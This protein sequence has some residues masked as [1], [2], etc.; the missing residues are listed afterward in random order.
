M[1]EDAIFALMDDVRS[2]SPD[3][4]GVVGPAEVSEPFARLWSKQ[5]G[6]SWRCK[7][8]QRIHVLRSLAR[9]AEAPPASLREMLAS[10]EELISGIIYNDS[11]VGLR[12]LLSVHGSGQPHFKPDLS[13]DRLSTGSR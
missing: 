6:G 7:F 9:T 4:S 11:V 1:P 8:R 10:D 5:Q 3:L 2:V 12:I 13:E